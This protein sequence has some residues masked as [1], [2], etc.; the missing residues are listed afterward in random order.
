MKQL[1]LNALGC[2]IHIYHRSRMPENGI[3]EVFR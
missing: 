3:R 1:A 2:K